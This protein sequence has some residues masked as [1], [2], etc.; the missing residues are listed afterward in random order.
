MSIAEFL[1]TTVLASPKVRAFANAL[2][3]KIL[4]VSVRI[5]DARVVLNPRDPVVSGALTLR[6]YENRE[7]AMFRRVLK[8]G[9]IVVDVGANVGLYTALAGLGIGSTGRVFAFE[10]EPE[11]FQYLEKTIARNQ[12]GN[13]VA[14]RAAATNED[15]EAP[16]FTSSSN[17]GDHRLYE[18]QLSDGC[19]TVRTVRLDDYLGSMG[20]S[21]VDIV[22]IDVQGFEGHVIAGMEDTIRR[23]PGLF[24]LMEFW[25]AGLVAA[26]TDPLGLLDRLGELGLSLH[27]VRRGGKFYALHDRHALLARLRGRKY[28][29]LALLGPQAEWA[30]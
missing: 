28:T 23:S 20:V 8:P 25:P 9:Q 12:L 30:K 3:L 11:S 18:S 22:K 5:G 4:P 1:Y 27:E 26:G 29:N 17:R 24:L 13:A 7:I 6:V 2:I 19:T 15:G 14:V 10:P 21:S 16:L